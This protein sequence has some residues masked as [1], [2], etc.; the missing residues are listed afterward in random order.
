MD[1]VRWDEYNFFIL[2]F[3]FSTI[4]V[5]IALFN[6][7][8]INFFRSNI[9]IRFFIYVI[10]AYFICSQWPAYVGP[11]RNPCRFLP[12][13][14]FAICFAT[15]FIL[16]Y[17]ERKN[18]SILQ[19]LGFVIICFLLSISKSA[20]QEKIFL[21]LQIIS[22]IL[23]LF[24]YYV[25]KKNFKSPFIYLTFAIFVLFTL[26]GDTK[27]TKIDIAEPVQLPRK[28]E[29]PPNFNHDG[30]I[31]T[32]GKVDN[33]PKPFYTSLY[34][35]RSG[36]YNIKTINGY[37]P[38]GYKDR[39]K[40]MGGKD[41]ARQIDNADKTEKILDAMLVPLAGANMCRA[42]AWRISTFVFPKDF[43]SKYQE[44]LEKCGYRI[45]A[46]PNAASK[47]YASLD[48]E[49]TN[50][51][52]KL[53][54]VTLPPL[55]GIVHESHEDAFD[56]LSLPARDAPMQIVFPRLYWHGFRASYNGE[57]LEVTPDE[58][59]LLTSVIIPAGPAGTLEFWF[60][61][62]TWRYMWISTALGLLGL[63]CV[64]IY[65]RRRRPQGFWTPALPR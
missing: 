60:F 18:S 65:V 19:Y 34:L 12:F 6:R 43:A 26:L 32:L 54:P 5:P 11:L 13:F 52:D 44:Q 9:E 1:Y 50:G 56:S 28:I 63:I 58:S 49:E 8:L 46:D 23:L 2:P 64:A 35:G 30:Y 29:F 31:F 53:P 45:G 55:E 37:T 24:V 10:L 27:F 38:L 20:G 42:N 21:Y 25:D 22:A 7:R 47:V 14:A 62:E 57:R 17:G 41:L 3:A 61:P 48:A 4:F 39:Y 33:F 59:G 15:S 40:I 16:E 51:W 36:L